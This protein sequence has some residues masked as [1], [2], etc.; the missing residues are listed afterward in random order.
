MAAPFFRQLWSLPGKLT[1]K[2]PFGWVATGRRFNYAYIY[3]QFNEHYFKE[4]LI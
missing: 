3:L 1:A 2:L 4:R